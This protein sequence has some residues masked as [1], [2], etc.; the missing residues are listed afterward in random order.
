MTKETPT[1][2][3]NYV[4][5]WRTYDYNSRKHM[6]PFWPC[7][8]EQLVKVSGECERVYSEACGVSS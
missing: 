7:S 6:K 3:K 4:L 5:W 2:D 8:D 1:D